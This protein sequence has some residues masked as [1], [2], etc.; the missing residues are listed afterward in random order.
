[1]I[2]IDKIYKAVQNRARK[3][4]GG[5]ISPDEFNLAV[6]KAV[7]D[8]YNQFRGRTKDYVHQKSSAIV[9]YAATQH[10]KDL[11]TY[12]QTSVVLTPNIEGYIKY[13]EDY[14]GYEDIEAIGSKVCQ[15]DVK[16]LVPKEAEVHIK[17]SDEKTTLINSVI[18]PPSLDTIYAFCEHR[19]K[20]IHIIPAKAA[21]KY[22][23]KYFKMTRTPV[24]AFT[25][26]D[27]GRPLYDAEN[28]I[29][30]DLPKSLREDIVNLI[31]IEVGV[32][33]SDQMLVQYSE[34]AAKQKGA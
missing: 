1:M 27:K 33:L 29:D 24:W 21:Q 9:E 31:C 16:R 22:R 30:I 19:S 15:D 8:I 23:L 17:R 4:Q 3:D 5:F 12:F 25:L 34:A 10:I 2:S 32:P 14:E 13:P 20:G 11:M 18:H 28:S 6:E 26:S 7:D